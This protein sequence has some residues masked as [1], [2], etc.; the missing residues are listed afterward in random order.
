[1]SLLGRG[2]H[3]NLKN[4]NGFFGYGFF[5][6]GTL[7]SLFT[8]LIFF[9]MFTNINIALNGGD[10]TNYG[11]FPAFSLII[12]GI[13]FFLLIGSI[14]MIFIN[15]TTRP[16]VILGYLL[17]LGAA[18]LEVIVGSSIFY[19]LIVFAEC[20]MYL[21]AGQ[22]I[23]N[24]NKIYKD[25]FVPKKR[26]KSKSSEWYYEKR[27][28]QNEYENIKK[29]KGIEKLEKELEE[30]KQLLDVGEVDEETYNQETNS[31]I[32]KVKKKN[33]QNNFQLFR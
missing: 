8:I 23:I 17:G 16:K 30:W 24:N 1:M 15:L 21:K 29:Q 28:E 11:Y 2:I 9:Q 27:N 5:A 12:G 26:K 10:G 19:F 32:E 13:Q 22:K 31:L 7:K 33:E 20:G 25:E 4:A 18:L 3:M 14:I 6:L